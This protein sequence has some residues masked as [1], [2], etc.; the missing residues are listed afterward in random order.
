CNV[1]GQHCCNQLI[2]HQSSTANL[3]FSI[4][5]LDSSTQPDSGSSLGIDC[6]PLGSIASGETCN[7]IPV[8]CSGDQT[9]NG[10]VNVGCSPISL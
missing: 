10:L 2:Q 6:S 3:I 4:L 8:C 1:A 9:Y 7:A 5:R